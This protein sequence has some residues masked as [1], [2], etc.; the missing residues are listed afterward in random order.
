MLFRSAM[1]LLNGRFNLAT[2]YML[3]AEMVAYQKDESR[4]KTAL[5]YMQEIIK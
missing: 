2:A 5:S 3:Y 4:Y 1:I